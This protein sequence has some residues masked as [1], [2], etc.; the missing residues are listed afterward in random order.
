MCSITIH[1]TLVPLFVSQNERH[2]EAVYEYMIVALFLL[3]NRSHSIRK[4]HLTHNS[5]ALVCGVMVTQMPA[6]N[7]IPYVVVILMPRTNVMYY[8]LVLY[9]TNK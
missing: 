6:I 4:L 7:L 1:Q 3:P 8:I 2:G 9:H 5:V